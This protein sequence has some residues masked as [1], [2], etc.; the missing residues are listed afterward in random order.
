MRSFEDVY[1]EAV[2]VEGQVSPALIGRLRG[3]YLAVA[4]G[5]GPVAVKPA[6]TDLLEYLASPG[7]KTDAHCRVVDYFFCLGDWSWDALPPGYQN[8]FADM[9]GGLHEAVAAPDI[10]EALDA[11][12]ESLLAR[13]RALPPRR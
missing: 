5:E 10:A 6:L 11:T 2:E 13:A 3:L 12:P 1:G 7:G 9:G 8:L 4:N